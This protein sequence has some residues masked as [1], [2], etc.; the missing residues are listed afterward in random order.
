MR[1]AVGDVM[2]I[3]AEGGGGHGGG[4]PSLVLDM[5]VVLGAAAVISVLLKRLKL[6]SIP[7]Y[8]LV[9]ALI[10]ALPLSLIGSQD[11]VEQ[12]SNIA[13]ILLMFTI[14]LHLDV[15]SIRSGMVP[16]LAVG[17]ASTLLTG[18]LLWP[19]GLPFGLTA[20]AAL[21][22]ALALSMSSTAVVLGILQQRKEVHLLHGRLCIGISIMQDLM[23]IA[24]LAALPVLAA[25]HRRV[26]PAIADAAAVASVGAA[27]GPDGS[28]GMAPWLQLV[29]T[30]CVAL[31]GIVTMLAFARY[32]LP[33]LLR[34]AS[35]GGNTE[36]LLVASAGAGLAAAMITAQLGFG[37][38]LGA[39]LAGFMLS[40]TPFRHQLVG[41]LAP[42]RDLFM[43]VFFT[44]VGVQL[45]LHAVLEY[46]WVI[47]IAV[48][49]TLAVKGGAIGLCVWLGG[50]TAPIA[51]LTAALLAQAGEFSLVIL[52]E[53]QTLGVVDDR[54]MGVA[55]PLV[56][57][58]LILTSP[59][60]DLARRH[61]G[62]LARIGPAR[63]ILARGLRE[64]GHG[65]A[66]HSPHPP[67][68]A[69][70]AA[71]AGDAAAGEDGV[72]PAGAAAPAPAPRHVIVA[73]FGIVGRNLAEHLAAAGI[74]FTVV[75][76]NP[77]TVTRQTQLGRSTV[78]GDITNPDVLESAGLAT[79]EAVMLTIPDDDAT[80][81]ACETIRRIRP[82]VFI[83]AR[84]SFLSRAMTALELGAD[85]VTIQEVVT[86][87][88]MAVKVMGELK[89]RYAAMDA[90]AGVP[91]L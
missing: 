91:H 60:A 72:A 88:D 48:A 7:G 67:H 20:P 33:H 83:A 27:A 69:S 38:A 76:L 28:A 64:H 4:G 79:A 5:L 71:A 84:T 44:A 32:V 65:H 35:R 21:A 1:G 61:Q 63:W 81:R 73:G 90:A 13:I 26:A 54:V 77:G 37:P 53:G 31:G 15:E 14:G 34:E 62:R 80:L 89:K 23:S 19:L 66:S 45:Q 49:L 51:A 22:V 2:H 86:A 3:L 57:V 10:N 75:E 29:T 74:P 12:I 6:A 58:S 78:F 9:G 18:L 17:A 11:N 87:Q 42:M 55:I 30:A 56:V 24:M 82:D 46:W 68:S 47:A 52:K 43:A 70:P 85:Q 40:S 25:W 50:A 59:A 16:I 39:F 8:L 41:Q 36:G